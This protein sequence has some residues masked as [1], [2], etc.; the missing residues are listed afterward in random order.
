MMMIKIVVCVL[1][2]WLYDAVMDCYRCWMLDLHIYH[3]QQ[4]IIIIDTLK[5][6]QQK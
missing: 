5:Q 4:P 3:S 6:K 2:L 1:C